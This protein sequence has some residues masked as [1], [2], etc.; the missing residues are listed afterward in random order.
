MNFDNSCCAYIVK[1]KYTE[2]GPECDLIMPE[3][4]LQIILF[5]VAKHLQITAFLAYVI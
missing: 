1:L 3:R 5:I 4:L 2:F